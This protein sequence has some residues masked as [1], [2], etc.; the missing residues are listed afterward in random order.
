G[1][2]LAWLV[3]WGRRGPHGGR[4]GC[5]VLAAV[6]VAGAAAVGTHRLPVGTVAV[7]TRPVAA[8]VAAGATS[9]WGRWLAL[10]VGLGLVVALALPAGAWL[11]GRVAR[12]P[13]R[14]QDRAET[15]VRS[16]RP[17][18]GS[19]LLALLRVDRAGVWRSVPTRR[20]MA[21]LAAF[22]AVLAVSGGFGWDTLGVLPGLVASGGALLFGVNAWSLDGRGARW[23]ESLPVSPRLGFVSRALVL[24]EILLLTIVATVL[25]ASLR[26]GPPS[27]SQLSAVVAAGVVV[28]VQVVARALRWSVRRP[29]SV[30]L[31]SLRVTPA[32]PL[33]M[34]GYSARLALT[35]TAT[36]LLFGALT[37]APWTWSP[38]AAAP[39]L[40][41][42]G[43]SLRRTARAWDDPAV[44]AGVVA[45]VAG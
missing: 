1:Q 29:C 41:W 30:D 21:V 36:G 9:S 6:V 34:V 33:V 23:R 19:D 16:A 18:P 15:A 43:L 40:V 20:G 13:S 31:R 17:H 32:P 5:A 45:T 14:A 27:S 42:S 37:V 8:A 11:A 39:F 4:H 12:L 22:P 44:R 26:A 25:V 10:T 38:V 35:T 2:A 24:A 3:E 7:V 28:T